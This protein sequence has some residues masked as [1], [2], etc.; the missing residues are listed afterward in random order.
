MKKFFTYLLLLSV[1]GINSS[2]TFKKKSKT[3]PPSSIEAKKDSVN[4]DY[5][6]ILRNATVKK[7][8]FTTIYNSKEGKLYFEIPDSVFTQTFI[9]S[10]RVAE[11]SNTQ[12]YVA[13]Q[14]ATTPFMFRMSKDDQRVYFH[15]VQNRNIIDSEDPMKPAL[16]KNFADPIFKGFK[17]AAK[18]GSNVVIEVT[19]LFGSNE[20]IISPIKS[21]G[22]SNSISANS[23]SKGTFMGDASGITEIKTFEKNIEIKSVLSYSTSA[24]DKAYTVTMHRSLFVLPEEPMNQ[25]L[26][27]NRSEERRVGKEC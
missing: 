9:L 2:F 8:L 19:S 18:N 10:N 6:K 1:I 27:D 23:N 17:I 4:G 12:D 16:D 14:M 21:S 13:G 22:N 24:S 25:R 5:K 15:T 26:Q 7:G 20:K 3:P 11:T